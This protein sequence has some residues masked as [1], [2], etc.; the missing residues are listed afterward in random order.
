MEQRKER[1]EDL[2]QYALCRS[3]AL[4]PLVAAQRGLRHLDVPVADVA[5][6]EVVEAPGSF[7]DVVA[8][9][10]LRDLLSDLLAAGEYPAVLKAQMGLVDGLGLVVEVHQGKPCR[11]PQLVHEVP[12]GFDLVGGEQDVPSL[13]GERRQGHAQRVC[14]VLVDHDEGVDDVAL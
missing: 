4:R 14:T 10:A 5:P 11:V 1:F 2:L 9:D 8:V 6:G 3:P 7:A 13:S 12:V